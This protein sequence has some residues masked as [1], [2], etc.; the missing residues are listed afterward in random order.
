MFVPLLTLL[1][2]A[3][4]PLIA[5]PTSVDR[6]QVRVGPPL[7]QTFRLTNHGQQTLIFSGVNSTNNP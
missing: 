5:D 7:T 1:I 4:D 6:G 3:Q 2:C